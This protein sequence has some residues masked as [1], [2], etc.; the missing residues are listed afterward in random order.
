[1]VSSLEVRL[2][3]WVR[4]DLSETVVCKEEIANELMNVLDS[5]RRGLCNLDQSF[6][7]AQEKSFNGALRDLIGVPAVENI[8]LDD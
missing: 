4:P 7:R 5:R 2:P 6:G 8:R 1:M 3:C